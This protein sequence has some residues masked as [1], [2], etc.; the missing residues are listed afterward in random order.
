MES[1]TVTRAIRAVSSY[2]AKPL[3][4]KG[5]QRKGNHFVRQS[6][7]VF[8]ILHFQASRWGTRDQGSFTINLAV[9]APSVFEAWCGKPFPKNPTTVLFPVQQRLG[10]CQPGKK[11]LW[12]DVSPTTNLEKLKQA[13]LKAVIDNG[14]GFFETFTS[15]ESILDRIETQGNLPG[16]QN[17]RLMRAILLA[18]LN[19]RLEA[20]VVLDQ[21]FQE[22]IP[23]EYA[24]VLTSVGKRLGLDCPIE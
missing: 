3:A 7:G 23:E 20:Q 10:F 5:F 21:C 24:L 18:L 17:P 1:S 15:M 14:I 4:P 11:D 2:L 9:T 12:W 8:H 6:Q 16:F 13:V 22:S 19:R